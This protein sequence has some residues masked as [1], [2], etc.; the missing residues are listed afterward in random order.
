MSKN[1]RLHSTCGVARSACGASHRRT[2][3]K[4]ED[5]ALIRR[6]GDNWLVCVADGA[7]SAS[8]SSE[9]ADLAVKTAMNW[10]LEHPFDPGS[11]SYQRYLRR[12]VLRV[13]N[14]LWEHAE[15]EDC[16]RED[17]ATTLI[18]AFAWPNGLIAA[19]IGDGIVAARTAELASEIVLLD[20][21][22]GAANVSDF[23]TDEDSL[24][25]TRCV[26]ISS[27]LSGIVISTDGLEGLMVGRDGKAYDPFFEPLFGWMQL[28][29]R[30]ARQKIAAFLQSERLRKATSD[31]VTLAIG[32]FE[33]NM[34]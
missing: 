22:C 23:V 10:M 11:E 17:L 8:R 5:A 9:G 32:T 19:Q 28:G 13:R 16:L 33:R 18:I 21:K 25:N 20:E 2:G 29:R 31:D 1:S 15:Q 26:Q 30:Q 12:C 6:L 34:P 27:A 3:G 4:C 14:T 24:K 7:G